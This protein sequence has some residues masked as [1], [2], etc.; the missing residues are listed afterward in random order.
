MKKEWLCQLVVLILFYLDSIISVEHGGVFL[1]ET[2]GIDLLYLLYKAILFLIVNYVLI[3]R[4]FHAKKYFLF[5]G[6]LI[7]TI[8][9]F[10]V[11]EEGF[12]EKILSP[13]SRGANDITWQSIYWYFGEILVPLLT[14]MTIKFVFDNFTQQQKL[15]RIEQDRLSNE[16]QL[17][18]SQIQPHILFNSLNNLYHFALKKSDAVPELILK[19]SNVLRYVLYETTEEKVPLKKELTFI[20]DFVDLQEIQY[21]GRGQIHFNIQFEQENDDLKIAPFLLIPFIENSF[22]HSFGS[23]I[24]EVSIEIKI[25]IQKNQ[26]QLFV[27]NNFEV[28]SGNSEK[29]TQG[30]I[31]LKNV[32]KRLELLYPNQYQ[33]NISKDEQEYFV[34]L[35]LKLV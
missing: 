25:I 24:K 1:S 16:L 34:H 22:K 3:P 13:N 17:L 32:K 7:S 21:K 29:L 5:F 19:L 35:E 15:E 28:D 6:L 30:G 10:G 23:K 27:I 9:L 14:F 33:L 4:F 2:P 20:K 18:K 11:I 12:V 26:I 8:V 31:G